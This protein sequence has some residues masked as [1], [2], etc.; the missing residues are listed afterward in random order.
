MVLGAASR[1]R[2]PDGKGQITQAQNGLMS[3]GHPSGWSLS[4]SGSRRLLRRAAG[5]YFVGPDGF[6]LWTTV[7][8]GFA[9]ALSL[10]Y[11]AL[12][13]KEDKA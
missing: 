11:L 6:H 12:S 13:E 2:P 7:S 3:E 8:L 10:A 9:V 5:V 4:P 1:S